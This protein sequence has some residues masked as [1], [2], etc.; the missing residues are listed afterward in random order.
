MRDRPPVGNPAHAAYTGWFA[1]SREAFPPLL[2][3]NSVTGIR[4]MGGGL[5]EF[6]DRRRDIEA[7]VWSD[8]GSSLRDRCWTDLFPPIL[9]RLASRRQRKACERCRL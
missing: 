3:A 2:G 5:Q 9:A 8:P 4:D 6:Q 1:G 7:G